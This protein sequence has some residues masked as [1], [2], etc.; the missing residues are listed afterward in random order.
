MVTVPLNAG[1]EAVVTLDHRTGDMTGYVLNRNSG[2]FFIRYHYNVTDDFPGT[3]GNYL[4]GAGLADFRGF[5]D[6]ERVA[7]GV[8]Y[9][10]EENSAQVAAYAIPWNTQLATSNAEPQDRQFIPLDRAQTR[11][12]NLR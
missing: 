6:N 11:F 7:S 9:V 4:M 12:T 10:A 3:R 8:I 5:Q 1:L 2:Q